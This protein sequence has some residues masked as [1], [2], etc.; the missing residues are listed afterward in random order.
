MTLGNHGWSG[1]IYDIGV[2]TIVL[3]LFS[4]YSAMQLGAL[5][6]DKVS[7]FSHY[8]LET[9]EKNSAVNELLEQLHK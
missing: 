2:S 3:Q 9:P 8:K 1:G 6:L 4:L 7:F 5:G